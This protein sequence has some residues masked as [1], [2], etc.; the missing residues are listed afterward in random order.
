M[1]AKK[2]TIGVVGAGRMGTGL[3]Q[4]FAYR[5]YNV[6]LVDSK[7][8][9]FEE[10]GRVLDKAEKQIEAHLSFLQS[11]SALPSFSVEKVRSRIKYYGAS[12]LEEALQ[13]ADVIFEAVPEVLDVK[14]AAFHRINAAVREDALIASTTSSFL[15]DTLAGYVMHPARFMNTHWLNPAYLIPLVEVSP[16]NE[17]DPMVMACM[18]TLLTEAGKVPVKCAA[19][20]GFIVPRIQALAMNEAARLVEEGIASPDDIDKASRIG[21]GLRFAVLGLLEFIDWGGGDVLY[22]A[23][24]YLKEELKAERYTPPDIIMEHMDTG[25]TGLKSGKGFYDFSQCDVSE[26]QRETLR[27]FVDLLY[28]LQLMALPADVMEETVK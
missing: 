2:Q 12:Q 4:V 18:M 15:V 27:K 17:T 26:Y 3:A 16:G 6:A 23:S 9:T 7:E 11:V 20:P 25:K 1:T 5:G 14:K 28:H 13:N 10:K 21:F 19:S 22:Y 8:R 24:N